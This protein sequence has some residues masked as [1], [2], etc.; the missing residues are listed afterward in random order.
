[1]VALFIKKKSNKMASLISLLIFCGSFDFF[2]THF[3]KAG[4]ADAVFI[5]FIGI[6]ILSLGLSSDNSNWYN[7]SFFMFALAFLTKSWHAVAV[8]PFKF[9]LLVVY[10]GI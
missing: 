6:A 2:R 3:V 9:F 8:L 5:L 10:K 1:M 7:L 4:D